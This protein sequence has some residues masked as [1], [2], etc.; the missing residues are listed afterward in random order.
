M[1]PWTTFKGRRKLDLA[2]VIDSQG[3]TS[4]ELVVAYFHRLHVE[5]PSQEEYEKAGAPAKKSNPAPST[6]GSTARRKSSGKAAKSKNET[7]QDNPE[8]VW[9]DAQDGAYQAKNTTTRRKT[10]TRKSTTRKKS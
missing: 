2:Q 4:Y 10:S 3:L 9:K 6:K 1:I 8:E 7:A 5:P